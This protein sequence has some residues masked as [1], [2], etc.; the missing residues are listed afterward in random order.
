MKNQLNLSEHMEGLNIF[1]ILKTMHSSELDD[2]ACIY[3]IFNR[4]VFHT[5]G[6]DKDYEIF[7]WILEMKSRIHMVVFHNYQK[8]L[9]DLVLN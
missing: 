9:N 3:N 2:R 6:F 4:S 7:Q 1:Y 8:I 5:P